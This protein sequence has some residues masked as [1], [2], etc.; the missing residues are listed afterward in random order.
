ML[1]WLKDR[2]LGHK[3][4]RKTIYENIKRPEFDYTGIINHGNDEDGWHCRTD[5]IKWTSDGQFLVSVGKEFTENDE[6]PFNKMIIWEN[7]NTFSK[8]RIK[9]KIDLKKTGFWSDDH[10]TTMQ[11]RDSRVIIGGYSRDR[12]TNEG[13]IIHFISLSNGKVEQTIT[14]AE[15]TSCIEFLSDNE[16][17]GLSGDNIIFHTDI[18]MKSDEMDYYYIHRYENKRRFHIF[19]SLSSNK[20]NT[21]EFIVGTYYDGLIFDIRQM[22]EPCCKFSNGPLDPLLRW[23]N[24]SWSPSGKYIYTR[25]ARKNEWEYDSW[26]N[27]DGDGTDNVC[28]FWDVQKSEQ[29]KIPIDSESIIWSDAQSWIGDNVILV[30]S[31]NIVTTTPHSQ[32]IENIVDSG[33]RPNRDVDDPFDSYTA[34][35]YNDKTRDSWTK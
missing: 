16:L 17:V 9:S 19:Q 11:C 21:N 18:R 31:G 5:C 3:T 1:K 14:V 34:L 30:S 24:V 23:L 35:E 32:S 26:E 28:F 22:K 20:S 10:W 27:S 13:G 4:N 6:K 7:P 2:Q 8:R 12:S 33:C 25:C 29:I 15:T